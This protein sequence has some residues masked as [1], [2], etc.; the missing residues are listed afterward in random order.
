MYKV[1]TTCISRYK[2]VCEGTVVK[3]N[4]DYVRPAEETEVKGVGFKHV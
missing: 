1:C 3:F 2:T 4:P